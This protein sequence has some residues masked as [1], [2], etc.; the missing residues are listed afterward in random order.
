[1]KTT[2]IKGAAV[3]ATLTLTMLSFAGAVGA[4]WETKADAGDRCD[5]AGNE[6]V[7]DGV[8]QCNTISPPSG[9]EHSGEPTERWACSSIAGS[10]PVKVSNTFR[11]NT[12]SL[13]WGSKDVA[14]IECERLAAAERAEAA[15]DYVWSDPDELRR[16][17]R[18]DD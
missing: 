12:V 10:G 6:R 7:F 18:Y 13:S 9:T 14:D 11:N 16:D 4:A 3:L 15:S 2:M 5:D 1:M 8:E 17:G